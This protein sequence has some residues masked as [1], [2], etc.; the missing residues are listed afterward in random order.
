MIYEYV[1]VVSLGPL[2]TRHSVGF[3]CFPLP[4]SQLIE[5]ESSF[6]KKGLYLLLEISPTY[7][8]F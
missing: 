2:Y 8:T 4:F 5:R 1:K 3:V 7:F 6:L